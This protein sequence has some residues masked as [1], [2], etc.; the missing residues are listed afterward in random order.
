MGKLD[1]KV[2]LVTGGAFGNGRAMALRFARDGAAVVIGDVDEPRLSES[3][4]LVH[5]LG[6]RALAQ[7]CD[8]SQRADIDSLVHRAVQEFGRLDVAVANAG[9]VEQ[10]TDCLRM[11]EAQWDRTI[12]INLKGVFFTLQAAAN[13]MVTQGTGGRSSRSRASWRN[14]AAPVRR[15]TARA[16][17]G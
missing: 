4:R 13:Q 3:A 9:V 15:R 2:A 1:G 16:R 5:D 8:V 10:E 14:G 12:D 7:R 11:T 6:G 17:A